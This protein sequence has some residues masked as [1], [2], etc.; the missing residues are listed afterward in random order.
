MLILSGSNTFEMQYGYIY[1]NKNTSDQISF[2][3]LLNVI[4]LKKF[5]S[6]VFFLAPVVFC[7]LFFCFLFSF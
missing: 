7:F 5:S 6:S 4:F 1:K 2:V 3:I